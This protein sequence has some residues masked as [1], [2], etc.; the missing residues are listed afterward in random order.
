MTRLFVYGTLLRGEG[1]HDFL[2][3]G[4]GAHFVR[5]ARTLPAYRLVAVGAFA[6]FPGLLLGGST[7]VDGEVFEV[8]AAVLSRVDMLEGHPRFYR[9]TPIVLEDGET[10]ETYLLPKAPGGSTDIVSG[11]WRRYRIAQ[12]AVRL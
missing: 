12:K 1:N 11:S 4:P 2:T 10:V 7:A 3:E 8:G 9:R 6:G 5:V